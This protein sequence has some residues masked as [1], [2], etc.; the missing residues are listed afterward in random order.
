V[1]RSPAALVY[2]EA[3]VGRELVGVEDVTARGRASTE[4]DS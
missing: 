2:E 3:D 1:S 4:Y